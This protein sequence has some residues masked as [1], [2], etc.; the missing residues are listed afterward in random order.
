M[1]FCKN[2]GNKLEDGAKFCPK[3]G[4]PTS[5]EVTASKSEGNSDEDANNQKV[6]CWSI[7]AIV[8]A[9]FVA[10]GYFSKNCSGD[11]SKA[12]DEPQAPQTTEQVAT[13]SQGNQETA[14]DG[15]FAEYEVND[16]AGRTL[17]VTL[18]EDKSAV[19]ICDGNTYYCSWSDQRSLDLGYFFKFSEISNVYF[20]FEGGT[21]D[22][23]ESFNL[24]IK[25]GYMYSDMTTSKAK[26]PKWRLEAK[27]TK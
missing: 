16:E 2:C 26:N 17:K 13:E 15:I 27:K 24:V 22:I 18:N 3:C 4:N 19:C 5:D 14:N 7:T 11:D 12:I 23:S 8:L 20:T 6:G 1:A 9:I 25:D 10:I 21:I